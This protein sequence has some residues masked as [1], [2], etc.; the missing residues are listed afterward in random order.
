MAINLKKQTAGNEKQ[1]MLPT[2]EPESSEDGMIE[3]SEENPEENMI[4]AMSIDTESASSF[5][6]FFSKSFNL[7][8]R[9]KIIF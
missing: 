1:Q 3:N 6:K 4:M 8:L 7:L 2:I 9:H 5:S